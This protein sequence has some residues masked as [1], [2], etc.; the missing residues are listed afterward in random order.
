MKVQGIACLVRLCETACLMTIQ[1]IACLLRLCGTA[2]LMKVQGITCLVRLCGTACL[3]R[4]Q[5]IT[6]LVRLWVTTCLMTQ[7]RD[8]LG[9]HSP[10]IRKQTS[11]DSIHAACRQREQRRVGRAVGYNRSVGIA[12]V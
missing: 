1:G 12:A 3:M 9:E 6:C 4:V 11:L 8:C 5:G 7:S 10:D 2:C